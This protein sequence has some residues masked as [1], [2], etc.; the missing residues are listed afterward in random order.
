LAG[1]RSLRSVVLDSSMSADDCR[2]LVEARPDLAVYHESIQASTE[3][4]AAVDWVL[5]NK[6]T[7][8]AYGAPAPVDSS[9][10]GP[11]L[12]LTLDFPVDSP[13]SSGWEHLPAL[14]GLQQ[15]YCMHAVEHADDLAA[16]VAKLDSLSNVG[17]NAE[18]LTAKGLS[19]LAALPHLEILALSH[20]SE[21]LTAEAWSAFRGKRLL[22]WVNLD[23]VLSDAALAE[24]AACPQLEVLTISGVRG[25]T[26]AGL[27]PLANCR[28]LTEIHLENTDLDD[29]GL[30]PLAKIRS[31]RLLFLD[32]TRVTPQGLARL[33]T[34]LPH[35]AIVYNGTMILPDPL[36]AVSKAAPT[37]R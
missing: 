13:P 16:Q 21:A 18:S 34:A 26:A 10:Q 6:G 2:V 11:F 4:Q 24:I 3:T 31:L 7:L 27:R 15:F 30:E 1:I 37:S 33:H 29:D 5:A 25:I 32:G 35:C 14:G 9:P 8:T 20:C 22:R 36:P 28:W 17:M 19:Q 12:A 23:G